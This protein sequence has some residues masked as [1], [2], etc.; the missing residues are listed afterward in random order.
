MILIDAKNFE[1]GIFS[2]SETRKEFRFIDFYKISNF[3]VQ[4]L[5][6][7]FQYR[8]CELEHLRTYFY[9]GEFT[10]KLIEKI[11]RTLD[12]S[13]KNKETIEK[14]LE[15]AKKNREKQA[16]FFKIARDYYF[17]EIRA[18]PLQ[19]SQSDLKILQKGVDVQLATDLV[20][21]TH[22]DVFD[23]AVILSGDIDLLESIKIAKNYGKHVIIFGN[24]EVTAEEMKKYADLFIDINRFT[25]EQLDKFTHIYIGDKNYNVKDE[26]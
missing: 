7:N 21:F 5:K 25:K 8:E 24:E 4:Y 23:V 6:N 11:Q 2:L 12:K 20:D 22:K 15:K 14:I 1:Q 18:K 3:I 9:T 10:D 16:K 19:F 26:K 17:F 13:N